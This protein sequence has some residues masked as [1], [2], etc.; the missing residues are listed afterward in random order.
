MQKL[1]VAGLMSL[2]VVGCN[3]GVSDSGDIASIGN[4]AS[5]GKT[6]QFSLAFSDA[7][8]DDLTQ[9]CVAFD[10]ITV[11]H[12]N[13]S[14]FNWGTSSFAADQSSV[15][16]TP[17]NDLNDIPGYEDGNPEFMVINLMAYQGEQSLQILSD[18]QMEAGEYTQMRLSV[19]ENG[20]YSDGTPYSNVVTNTNDT[21]G[22]R[23][24]SGELKL[25]GFVVGAETS[26]TYTLEFDLRKSMVLNNN[27]YQ[28]KP[29]GVRLVSNEEVATISGGIQ[30]GSEV[31]SGVLDNAF[32]YIYKAPTDGNHGDL[33]SESEP[34]A[35]VAVDKD[36]HSFAVGYLPFG[37]YDIALVC[38]G[39]EDQ[40]EIAGD[41][42][43][44]DSV[45]ADETLTAAGATYVY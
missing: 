5:T 44:I 18:E 16:C 30:E 13:G 2:T 4:S 34:Y 40:S 21:Q 27:G 45:L 35:S 7:P 11:L 33:G 19:L 37:S 6:A 22:M 15:E 3:S 31:C 38:N 39:N 20:S 8:V 41:Q 28:L 17:N 29:R 24:P 9:V 42:L 32:V 1:L 25:D 43:D 14:E 26:E 12:E 36:T 23:V 10:E